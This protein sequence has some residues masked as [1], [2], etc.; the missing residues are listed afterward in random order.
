MNNR[1]NNI[2]QKHNFRIINKYRFE[3]MT[4]VCPHC[5]GMTSI[6][7]GIEENECSICR[8]RISGEDLEATNEI[9]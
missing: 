8:R 3:I 2:T 1:N 4:V 6:V 5:F 9:I 7:E